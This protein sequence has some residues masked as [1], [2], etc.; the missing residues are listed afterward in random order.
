MG[1]RSFASFAEASAFA[2]KLAQEHRMPVRV[3]RSG[4]GF[5]VEVTQPAV[6]AKGHGSKA[7]EPVVAGDVRPP[8]SLVQAGSASPESVHAP[9]GR[10]CN[11]CGRTI[12]QA[13]ISANPNASRCVACQSSYEK[14]HDTRQ[15]A[16]EGIGGT[17]AENKQL[18]ARLWGDMRNRGRGR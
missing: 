14:A 15:K 6:A 3:V 1:A 11:D 10:P 9:V 4:D 7:M 5:V 18:R 12:P 17:R 16:G 2:K 8:Q 13:R